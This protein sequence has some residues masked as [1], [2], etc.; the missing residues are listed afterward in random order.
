MLW[1]VMLYYPMLWYGKES[2]VWYEISMLWDKIS[3]LCYV[4]VNVVKDKHSA[5]VIIDRSMVF[6]S[7]ML[8]L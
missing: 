4:M 3:F 8:L 1:Y 5:T 7:K 6:S 2:M